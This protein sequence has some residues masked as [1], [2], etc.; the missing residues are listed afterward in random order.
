VTS[1]DIDLGCDLEKIE[2]HSDAFVSDYFT[3]N[4]QRWIEQVPAADRLTLIPI[5]WSAK[6]SALKVLRIGLRADTRS[7]EVQFSAEF[8]TDLLSRDGRDEWFPLNASQQDGSVFLGWWS[9]NEG[10]VKT[11]LAL[12]RSQAPISLSE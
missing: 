8:V 12:V 5:L 4:E 6:E 10:M 2:P 7:V 1:S 9:V 11:V 3:S